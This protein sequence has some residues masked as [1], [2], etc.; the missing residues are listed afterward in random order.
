MECNGLRTLYRPYLQQFKVSNNFSVSKISD[1]RWS[2]SEATLLAQSK[3][4]GEVVEWNVHGLSNYDS[5]YDYV[6]IT[7]Q[8]LFNCKNLRRVL[9]ESKDI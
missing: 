1:N 5:C 3:S 9:S 7:L 2:L 8:S 4:C 6:N